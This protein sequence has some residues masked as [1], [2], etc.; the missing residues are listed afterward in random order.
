MSSLRVLVSF[1]TVT[2]DR[3]SAVKSNEDGQVAQAGAAALK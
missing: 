2:A 3:A 1:R